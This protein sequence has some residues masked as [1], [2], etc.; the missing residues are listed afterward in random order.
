MRALDPRLSQGLAV[1]IA[2][3][4][5]VLSWRFGYH[6]AVHRFRQDRVQVAALTARIAQIDVVMQR[7]G[8]TAKWL[9]DNQR[10]L[11]TLRAKFPQHEQMPQLL[12]A[13]V[14]AL[15]TGEVDLVNMTQGNLE[16][17]QANNA[18]LLID[19]TP[20]YR[21]PVT[22]ITEGRYHAVLAALER[23][24]D[25]TFPTVVSIEQVD[26]HLKDAAGATLEA[27]LHLNVYV[28]G[29]TLDSSPHA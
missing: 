22:M 6:R 13:L 15:K 21:L 11:A 19:G 23:L 28:T 14:D 1:V 24:M 10:R 5:C 25:E 20:C 18:P 3:I 16:R 2:G 7:A 12:N 27:T 4:A 9:A 26:F 17:V 8:G 29:P